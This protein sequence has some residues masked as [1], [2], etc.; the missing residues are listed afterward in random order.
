MGSSLLMAREYML[1][2][3][4]QQFVIKRRDRSAGIAEYDVGVFE[5]KRF[6]DSFCSCYLHIVPPFPALSYQFS[7]L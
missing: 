6:D 4:F 7:S 1:Y 5:F 3:A 2:T